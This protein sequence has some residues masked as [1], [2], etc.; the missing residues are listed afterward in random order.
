MARE[1]ELETLL[2]PKIP[3]E[4]A[5]RAFERLAA[6]ERRSTVKKFGRCGAYENWT[7]AES[8]SRGRR[9]ILQDVFERLI[10]GQKIQ[11]T[12]K[13]GEDRVLAVVDRAVRIQKL[14]ALPGRHACL[15]EGCLRWRQHGHEG[16]CRKHYLEKTEWER[17]QGLSTQRDTQDAMTSAGAVV[18]GGRSRWL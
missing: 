1:V 10:I 7:L 2:S 12:S 16:L 9:E 3:P 18:S 5:R 6:V 11:R 13:R 8:I 15:I 14:E 17:A 4:A